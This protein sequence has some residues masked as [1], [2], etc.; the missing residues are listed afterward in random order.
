LTIFSTIGPPTRG[1]WVD[2]LTQGS[3]ASLAAIARREGKVER[4]VRLLAPLA[5]VARGSRPP[6]PRGPAGPA[7][8]RH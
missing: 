4:H 3:A 5:G 8:R 7:D 2:D 6:A 1:F